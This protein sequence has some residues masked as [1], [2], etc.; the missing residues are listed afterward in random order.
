MRLNSVASGRRG[1]GRRADARAGAQAR[2]TFHDIALRCRRTAATY[3]AVWIV[4]AERMKAGREHRVPL[5]DRALEVL[6]GA[7][8]LAER[9]C[10]RPG[11]GASTSTCS[12][13]SGSAGASPSGP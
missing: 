2:A 8:E 11:S 1:T 12:S 10:G 13:L 7:R 4:P 9:G 6:D 5:S 3:G